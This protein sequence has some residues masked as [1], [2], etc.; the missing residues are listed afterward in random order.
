[1]AYSLT[2]T[3]KCLDYNTFS[4]QYKTGLLVVETAEAFKGRPLNDAEYKNAA[5]LGWA[6]IFVR[7]TFSSSFPCVT[8]RA[9]LHSYF[10]VSDNIVDQV[11][12]THGKLAWHRMAGVGWKALNDAFLLD[13]A[14]Y[15]LLREHL[16]QEPYYVD[17]LELLHETRHPAF[18]RNPIPVGV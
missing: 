15:Q 8:I 14:V 11:A 13:G 6:L 2:W 12:T 9:Q 4:G 18:F 7:P 1:M 17:L 10:V 3:T 16:R 5:I